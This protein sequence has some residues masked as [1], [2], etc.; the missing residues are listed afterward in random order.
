M[1]IKSP[2]EIKGLNDPA[3][4][5]QAAFFFDQ[6]VHP[7]VFPKGRAWWTILE[8]SWNGMDTPGACA[9][10]MAGGRDDNGLELTWN[11]PWFPENKYGKLHSGTFGALRLEWEYVRMRADLNVAWEEY[12]RAACRVAAQSKWELPVLYEP[13]DW[14]IAAALESEPPKSPKIPEAAMAGDPW[15]I[16]VHTEPNE[17]LQKLLMLDTYRV[18][19]TEQM[20]QGVKDVMTMSQSELDHRIGAAIDQ[21]LAKAAAAGFKQPKAQRPKAKKQG[22]AYNAFVSEQMAL[23]KSLAEIG[24]LWQE[25]KVFMAGA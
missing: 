1:P 9:E 19:P 14:R 21:A 18:Q 6:H 10:Y 11:A 22:S 20:V 23:G 4:T 8:K 2:Q 25:K 16:G 3:R 5:K 17:R 7:R 15:L 13:V 12:H 24:P